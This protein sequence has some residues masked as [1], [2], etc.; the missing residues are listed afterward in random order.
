MN[1]SHRLDLIYKVN[2]SIN[3]FCSPIL[4]L[5]LLFQFFLSLAWLVCIFRKLLKRSKT[6]KSTNIKTKQLWNEMWNNHYS[7]EIRDLF[8]IMIC[9]C[10]S[11]FVIITVAYGVIYFFVILP[12]R[13]NTKMRFSEILQY[14]QDSDHVYDFGKGFFLSLF[15]FEDRLVRALLFFTPYCLMIFVR[16]LTQF[17]VH[18]YSFYSYNM[19]L[20]M[21]FGI[22]LSFAIALYIVGLFRIFM[23]PFYII[24]AFAI[25][26]EYLVTIKVTRQLRRLLKQRLT[27]ALN[28]ESADIC[29]Y[30]KTVYG[31]YKNFSVVLLLSLFFQITSISI[32]C[33]HSVVVTM[34]VSPGDWFEF[35]FYQSNVSNIVYLFNSHPNVI[36]YNLSVCSIQEAFLTI[37]LS[38]QI[39]PYL[40]VSLRTLLRAI[41]RRARGYNVNTML[42]Q[43]LIER[44]NNDYARNH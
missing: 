1:N 35:I 19:N 9:L 4:F 42:I 16:I 31:N 17:M 13:T 14:R 43:R 27:D 3:L 7:Y 44:H 20:K 33:I 37:G 25:L 32:F 8:L 41:K 39:V 24:T 36:K 38:L 2:A 30:Y 5:I 18:K 40:F 28:N 22:S 26:F 11:A 23:A 12:Y 34:L 15:H 6:L 29:S 21:K 10:E